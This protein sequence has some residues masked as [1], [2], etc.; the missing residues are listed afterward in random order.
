MKL[1]FLILCLLPLSAL[2]NW[3]MEV[4]LGVDGETFKANE[5]K[6]EEGKE[7]KLNLGRYVVKLTIKKS[8]EPKYLDVSYA[9]EE[10]KGDK[11]ILVNKG[12]ESI[13]DKSSGEIYAKGE[14]SQ[15]NSIIT[16]K[17]KK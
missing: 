6:F 10:K 3:N 1:V 9:V 16:L 5:A 7:T 13:E 17:P 14:P 15:P 2:A 11:F 4:T 8:D 12:E